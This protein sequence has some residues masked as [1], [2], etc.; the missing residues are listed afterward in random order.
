MDEKSLQKWA[1]NFNYSNTE[2]LTLIHLQHNDLKGAPSHQ[3]NQL[4]E[5]IYSIMARKLKVDMEKSRFLSL[6]K[7]YIE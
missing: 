5:G 2:N 4:F 6:D 3:S 7:T 1:N